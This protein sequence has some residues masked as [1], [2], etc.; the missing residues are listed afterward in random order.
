MYNSRITLLILLLLPIV[1]F[2]QRDELK[3][4]QVNISVLFNYNSDHP[5]FSWTTFA[6]G[7]VSDVDL[8]FLTPNSGTFELETDSLEFNVTNRLNLP[9]S[10]IGLGFSIQI[11][12]PSQLYHEIQVPTLQLTTHDNF[13]R[14][15]RINLND[16]RGSFDRTV[17]ESLSSFILAMKYEV[18]KYLGNV[19]NNKFRLGIG[20]NVSTLFYSFNAES[21]FGFEETSSL[22]PPFVGSFLDINFGLGSNAWLQVSELMS[23]ELRF[24]PYVRLA[25]LGDIRFESPLLLSR[26]SPGERS[27]DSPSFGTT[28]QLGLK[29]KLKDFENGD[30]RSRRRR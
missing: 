11:I 2:G 27:G 24:A 25:S 20:F 14:T 23:L 10:R 1:L 12:N 8:D 4:K 26:L 6:T 9:K 28:V 19:Q 7:R 13:T 15:E 16:P 5:E 30:K 18:G 17:N 22:G 21:T 29:F 3:G